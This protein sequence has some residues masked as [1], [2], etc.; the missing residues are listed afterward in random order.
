MSMPRKVMLIWL[1]P[2]DARKMRERSKMK[3][4]KEYF[5]GE[6]ESLLSLT[7]S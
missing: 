4:W 2:G 5:T 7:L 1:V 6:L 3:L